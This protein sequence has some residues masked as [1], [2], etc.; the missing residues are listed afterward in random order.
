LYGKGGDEFGKLGNEKL[1]H[2][3]GKGFKKEKTKLK[4]KNFCG[5]DVTIN[6]HAINSIKLK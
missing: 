6:M 2:T 1:K 5:G 4:N 3:V